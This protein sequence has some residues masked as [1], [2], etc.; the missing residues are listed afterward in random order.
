MFVGLENAFGAKL[1]I[2]LAVLIIFFGIRTIKSGTLLQS[3]SLFAYQGLIFTYDSVILL[4][5][6]GGA[7]QNRDMFGMIGHSKLGLSKS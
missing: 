4:A 1:S 7:L 2:V 6:H 5:F 3:S